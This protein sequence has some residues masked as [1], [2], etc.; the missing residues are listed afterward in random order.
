MNTFHERLKFERTKRGMTQKEFGQILEITQSQMANIEK[1]INSL[2]VD[3]L[4]ILHKKL[5][6]DLNFLI[7]GEY[8]RLDYGLD[9]MDFSQLKKLNADIF[10]ELESRNN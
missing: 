5:G 6:V 10:N 8:L 7:T 1:G 2:T 4:V 3:K 9:K